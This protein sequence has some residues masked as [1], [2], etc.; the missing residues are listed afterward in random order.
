MAEALR[1]RRDCPWASQLLRGITEIQGQLQHVVLDRGASEVL[2]LHGTTDEKAQEIVKQGFDE[3][4]TQRQLYGRGV[5][6]T[7]DACKAMQYVGNGSSRCI[8]VARVLL[9]HPFIAQGPMLTHER[10][11]IAPGY[12]VPHDSIV[13]QP[14][15]EHPEW[16][17]GRQGPGQTAAH[18]GGGAQS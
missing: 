2:L 11:P 16:E 1:G 13:A 5:C 14:T 3:R 12:G 8:I 10:P 7:T 15:T 6:F 4:L 9:G 18:R 17:R